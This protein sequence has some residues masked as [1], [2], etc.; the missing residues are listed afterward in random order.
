MD[1]TKPL[2]IIQGQTIKEN[3]IIDIDGTGNMQKIEY[4]ID[5]TKT[6]PLAQTMYSTL[7][8]YENK[9]WSAINKGVKTGFP[10][11]DKAFI[12]G[13][14]SGF[15]MIA[16]DANLGKSL[17]LTQLTWQML[18]NNPDVFI[19][20]FSL[21]DPMD[22]KV[23]KLIASWK[24][25]PINYAKFPNGQ[26]ELVLARR[27]QGLVDLINNADR[28]LCYDNTFGSSIE[29]IEAKVEEVKVMLEAYRPGTRLVVLIDSFHDLQ[30][31]AEPSLSETAK[32]NKLA[33]RVADLAIKFDLVLICTGELRKGDE[34]ST[35]NLRPNL[36]A[37]RESVKIRYEAKAVILIYQDVHYKGDNADVFYLRPND[38]TK[39]PVLELHIAKNKISSY[40]GR[41]FYYMYPELC[42]LVECNDAVSKQFRTLI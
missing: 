18:E 22:D 37:I 40:K 21:D 4:D 33:Q 10:A 13:F 17:V 19:L 3:C 34:K 9:S 14:A 27:M 11:L 29:L 30:I 12:D 42:K 25:L 38:Q 5:T 35:G 6:F 24:S 36:G 15:Y 32:F 7:H 31:D 26:S 23:S 28:Y 16:G 39:Y 8:N 2:Q 1:I 41:L 20:D